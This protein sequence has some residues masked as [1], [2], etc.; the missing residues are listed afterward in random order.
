ME[1]ER[2]KLIK[3]IVVQELLQALYDKM[4]AKK[5]SSL[6]FEE[7]REISDDVIK[8]IKQ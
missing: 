3:E 5:T 1:K 6:S 8:K 4:I 2:L 7:M